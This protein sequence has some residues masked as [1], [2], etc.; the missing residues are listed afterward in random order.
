MPKIAY[1][2]KKFTKGSL[3][4]IQYANSFIRT[5]A[6]QGLS[7]TLPNCI[8]NSFPRRF[9]RTQNGTTNAS[10]ISAMHGWLG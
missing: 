9:S 5:Y 8:T 10:Q 3:E 7:L 4:I 6:A 2:T 1:E